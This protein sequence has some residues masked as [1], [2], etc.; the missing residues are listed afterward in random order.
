MINWDAYT[1][2]TADEF[3]CKCGC[4]FVAMDGDFMSRI[5]LV[6]SSVGFAM[7]VTS[8]FRCHKHDEKIGG[9]GV[10]PTG[11]AADFNLHGSQVFEVVAVAA[12]FGLHRIGL[13]Q[14]GLRVN[15]FIH[16][17]NL[18]DDKHPTPWIWTY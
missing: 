8:G 7:P 17:D 3:R 5:Q 14:K 13:N 2:F 6:R 10:H 12:K 9:A 16:L 1:N 18:V 15:R 4:G 11:Q